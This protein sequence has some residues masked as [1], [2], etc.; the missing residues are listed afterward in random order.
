MYLFSYKCVEVRLSNVPSGA[1]LVGE[2]I[3][4]DRH[5]ENNDAHAPLQLSSSVTLYSANELLSGL[6]SNHPGRHFLGFSA[7]CYVL[8]TSSMTFSCLYYS[9]SSH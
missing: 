2:R 5:L 6:L 1:S 3:S 7:A 8:W 4:G 9:L